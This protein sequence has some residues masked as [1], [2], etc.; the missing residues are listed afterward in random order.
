M[1]RNRRTMTAGNGCENPASV[2]ETC[3][4]MKRASS[5]AREQRTSGRVLYDDFTVGKSCSIVADKFMESSF[6]IKIALHSSA[7]QKLDM[8]PLAEV[9]AC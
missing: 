6:L 5:D 2:P 8:W 3:S 4:Q 1:G 9:S 7:E